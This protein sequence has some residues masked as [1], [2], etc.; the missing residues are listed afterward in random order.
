[1]TNLQRTTLRHRLTTLCALLTVAA[2]AFTGFDSYQR[3]RHTIEQ[4]THE[5]LVAM[6][7]LVAYQVRSGVEFEAIDEV[8]SALE[9]ARSTMDLQAAAVYLQGGRQF[10]CNGDPT[11]LPADS[12]AGRPATD[13]WIVEARMPYRDGNGESAYGLVLARASGQPARDAIAAYL[14]GLVVTDLLALLV[15]G[16][17]ARW[18]LDRLLRP[19]QALI[20]TTHQVRTSEDYSLRAEAVS[21]D[22]VGVLVRAFNSMLAT[23]EERDAHLASN[24]ERLEA[25]VQERTAALRQALAAAESATRAKS[26]F[27]ANM[28]HEIRTPLNAVLGMA[29]LAMEADDPQEL[30]EYLGVI[31]NAGANLLGILC[32]IL[33]LSKIESD[34]LELSPVPTDLEALVIE[35]LRPLTARI[36]SRQLELSCEVDPALARA[37]LVDDVR[38]RQVLTNLVG[39]AIKFTERGFV[40]V[41]VRQLATRGDQH[42]IELVVEDTGVGIPADRLAAI[43][44]PFTQADATITRRFAG[45]GLGL[46]ITDRLVRMMDGHI[47]VE[48]TLGAGTTFRVRLPLTACASVLPATPRLEPGVRVLLVSRSELLRRSLR[49]IA[50]RG[51]FELVEFDDVGQLSAAGALGAHDRVLVDERDP[52]ADEALCAAVPPAGGD[53]RPL[54]LVTSLQDL[55]TTSARCR[56]NRYAGYLTKPVSGRELLLR[57][58]GIDHQHAANATPNPAGGAAAIAGERRALRVLVAEDNAVNQKLIE[59][60]LQRDGHDVTIA[61]NGRECCEAWQQRA[62]DL[63][64]MDM[65]MPEM[66]GLEATARIRRDE[67][68]TGDH[69]PIIAL[70]AN[71]SIEDRTACIDAGMDD[72]LSKPVS[73]PKLREVLARFGIDPDD[74]HPTRLSP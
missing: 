39:N 31:R 1:M 3:E 72:V 70:T 32:D 35:S 73:I 50:P 21:D 22:E 29:D 43:F 34:K 69:V 12:R 60:I 30:R 33:D 47:H 37:F 63:V 48:S 28:S 41:A 67:R 64:L 20:S 26:T 36:Q 24:A 4:N 18:L 6:A 15:L 68:I 13:D 16:L 54:L 53:T 65:Q 52:D 27:V 2:L 62:F 56:S 58:G 38:L 9:A 61:G 25:Q 45:T 46:S 11:L 10:A 40:R 19:I 49:A 7:R 44:T 55:A 5:R 17:A 51:P 23:I 66:S 14:R 8:R 74:H 71:T 59:R 57:L 42:D